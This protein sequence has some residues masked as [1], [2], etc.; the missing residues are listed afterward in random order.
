MRGKRGG[1][2]ERLRR[3]DGRGRQAWSAWPRRT[4]V[5][6]TKPA[7]PRSAATSRP[8]GR[9]SSSNA[10]ARSPTPKPD[11][12]KPIRCILIPLSCGCRVKVYAEPF[13]RG[14]RSGY[15]RSLRYSCHDGVS[16]RSERPL[17]KSPFNAS[18]RLVSDACSV[19]PGRAEVCGRANLTHEITTCGGPVKRR[20]GAITRS[21]FGG[22]T[23]RVVSR[24][25]ALGTTATT[26]TPARDSRRDDN[27]AGP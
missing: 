25:L 1:M 26:G 6:T 19:H 15:D 12:T 21:T 5:T 17:R 4:V 8:I 9:S 27:I 24:W 3:N 23:R 22:I 13:R 10:R 14:A 2:I 18:T 20:S 11:G 16:R 7:T